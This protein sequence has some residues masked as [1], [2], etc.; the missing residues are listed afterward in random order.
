M[1][2]GGT[3]FQECRHEHQIFSVLWALSLAKKLIPYRH[4]S[5]GRHA[6]LTHTNQLLMTI[7]FLRQYPT[8]EV[9]AFLFGVSS[10]L[11]LVW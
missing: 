8:N 10:R 4:D 9:L 2:L 3:N 7:V 11:P 1:Y 6:D 5:G